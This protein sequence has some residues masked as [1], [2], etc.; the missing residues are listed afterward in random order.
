MQTMFLLLI[1]TQWHSALASRLDLVP[2]ARAAVRSGFGDGS[3]AW[4]GTLGQ[5]AWN[6]IECLFYATWWRLRDVRLPVLPLF[7]LLVFY[8]LTDVFAADFTRYA[9]AHPRLAPFLA[10]IAGVQATWG[11]AA[12]HGGAALAF[13]GFGVLTVLRLFGTIQAQTACGAPRAAAVR[14]T[15]AAW[16]ACR[17]ILWWS[18]DLARGASPVN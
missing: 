13:G 12:G 3:A 17:L 6:A 1:A 5:F 8:S 4:I 11:G 14:L 15:L 7:A 16:L 9:W 10:W 2:A 18:L